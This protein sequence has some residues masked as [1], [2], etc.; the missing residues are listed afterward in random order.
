[1]LT[2]ISI[3][4][5]WLLLL[6]L[7]FFFFFLSEGSLLGE[8]FVVVRGEDNQLR[9]FYN[10]CRHHATVL[11]PPGCTHHA[12]NKENFVCCYHGWTYGLDGR[13]LKAT[14]LK[15]IKNFSAKDYGLKSIPLSQWGP[16]VFVWLGEQRTNLPSIQEI[17]KPV[18]NH[19]SSMKFGDLGD[20]KFVSREVHVVNSNWKIVNDNYLDGEYH[21]P[22]VHNGLFSILEM[23]AYKAE[24]PNRDISLQIASPN[25]QATNTT[26]SAVKEGEDFTE[27]IGDRGAVYG[28]LYPNFAI[29]RYG[30]MLDTNLVIPI[31]HDKTAI[32]FDY[33]FEEK[34]M[35]DKDFLQKSIAASRKVQEEDTSVCELIQEGLTTKGYNTGRYSPT[36]ETPTYHFHQFLSD[37][38]HKYVATKQ[39]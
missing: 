10:V 31:S 30:P 3:F 38:L 36:M 12:G 22:H 32:I 24:L 2:F 19:I 11:S 26:S 9:A 4:L 27:R 6:L 13:L 39:R 15:G 37:C 35:N 33:F 34:Y 14:K 18:D 1:M 25:K 28:L 17:L 21:I 16:Y 5:F 20:L 8:H 23:K 29:N 7:L